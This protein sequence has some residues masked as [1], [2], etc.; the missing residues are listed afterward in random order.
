MELPL[1]SRKHCLE[2]LVLIFEIAEILSFFNQI[3]VHLNEII[4]NPYLLVK[5]SPEASDHQQA[6]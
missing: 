5:L 6:F 4:I 1:N 2:L 3:F